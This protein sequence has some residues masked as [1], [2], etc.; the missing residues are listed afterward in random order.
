MRQAKYYDKEEEEQQ[1]ELDHRIA[2]VRTACNNC[3]TGG[4]KGLVT[5]TGFFFT[6][7]LINFIGQ[8]WS[9]I[10]ITDIVPT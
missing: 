7:T 8:A 10:N 5:A 9:I 6:L 3:A 4:W 1:D 2:A